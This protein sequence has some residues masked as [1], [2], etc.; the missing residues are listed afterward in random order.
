MSLTKQLATVPD[1]PSSGVRLTQPS[2]AIRSLA[3]SWSEES[4]VGDVYLQ[5]I[6]LRVRQK[7]SGKMPQILL[8]LVQKNTVP[9]L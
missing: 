6:L 5:F 2:T 3:A 4:I 1:H 9:T 8:S 7:N